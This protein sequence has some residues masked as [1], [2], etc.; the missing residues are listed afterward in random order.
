MAQKG[1]L[2]MTYVQGGPSP[3]E[4]RLGWLWFWLF[5]PL[6]GSAWADR[7]LAELA[8]QLGKMVEHPKSKSAQP[9]FTR[10]WATLCE[11]L[12]CLCSTYYTASWKNR[13]KNRPKSK[14][15]YWIVP[16]SVVAAD[17]V[18]RVLSSHGAP[19]DILHTHL[20][21]VDD[22]EERESLARNSIL[23]DRWLIKFWFGFYSKVVSDSQLIRAEPIP[24]LRAGN[25]I[26][27]M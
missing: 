24:S 9:R 16:K 7:K 27:W 25:R 4:P 20:N 17:G 2:K 23:Q 15:I 26:S 22:V 1:F 5:H 3:G 13:P 18:V 19:A 6:P 12:E 11:L 10:R 14:N 8:D 21:L